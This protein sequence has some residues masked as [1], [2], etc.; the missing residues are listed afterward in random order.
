MGNIRSD[1][2]PTYIDVSITRHLILTMPQQKVTKQE[3]QELVKKFKAKKLVKDNDLIGELM[4]RF[5]ARGDKVDL[6]KMR[7]AYME[8]YPDTSLPPPKKKKEKKGKGKGR[9]ET[10][11]PTQAG[12]EPEVII[13]ETV[14]DAGEVKK[15]SQAEVVISEPLPDA[16]E[17][18]E[19][20]ETSHDEVVMPPEATEV[21]DVRKTSENMPDG[22]DEVPELARASQDETK[23]ETIHNLTEPETVKDPTE[24]IAI[25]AEEPPNI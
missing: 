2:L 19:A 8:M 14:P 13:S 16:S 3:F 17:V 24:E 1:L 11:I 4:K 23:T 6:I 25:A 9:L 12:E 20:K 18:E 15:P 5:K 22:T 21:L 7:A 10:K